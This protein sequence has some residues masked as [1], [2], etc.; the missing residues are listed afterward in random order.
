MAYIT[1]TNASNS[2]LD[3]MGAVLEAGGK[4]LEHVP[5]ANGL[6]ITR[7]AHGTKGLESIATLSHFDF[8]DL[9]T[10]NHQPLSQLAADS[11]F[12]ARAETL[13]KRL[14]LKPLPETEAFAAFREDTVETGVT[15]GANAYARQ[16]A[17]TAA[18]TPRPKDSWNDDIAIVGGVEG[19]NEI[20]GR[21]KDGVRKEDGTLLT[22][23]AARY[24][25]VPRLSLKHLEQVVD[26]IAAHKDKGDDVYVLDYG[27]GHGRFLIPVFDMLGERGL[28]PKILAYDP[29]PNALEALKDNIESRNEIS[30]L[31]GFD[32]RIISYAE[33]SH[34]DVIILN[35]PKYLKQFAGK[36]D[37]AMSM[38]G[39]IHHADSETQLH[40]SLNDI[41][42]TLSGYGLFVGTG[43][44]A[45]LRY[46]EKMLAKIDMRHAGNLFADVSG[47]VPA[48]RGDSEFI[49]T[50]NPDYASKIKKEQAQEKDVAKIAAAYGMDL[51]ELAVQVAE[52]SAQ[53]RSLGHPIYSEGG[54]LTPA[55][56]VAAEQA[57]TMFARHRGKDIVV[58]WTYRLETQES[59]AHLLSGHGIAAETWKPD[60]FNHNDAAAAD[61]ATVQ[62][63]LRLAASP[64]LSGKAQPDTSFDYW[65][66]A[67]NKAGFLEQKVRSD[68]SACMPHLTE[69][70]NY[71]DMLTQHLP[72]FLDKQGFN[73]PFIEKLRDTF[74]NKATS[75]PAWVDN[76]T[77]RHIA[78]S[79]ADI[80]GFEERIALNGSQSI[81]H[82]GRALKGE[83]AYDTYAGIC[84]PQKRAEALQ[85]GEIFLASA[86]RFVAAD[87]AG[88]DHIKAAAS[89][90]AQRL[91]DELIE[92]Y[93][94]YKKRVLQYLCLETPPAPAAARHDAG[95]RENRF[96]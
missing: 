68:I 41:K 55:W 46:R 39:A 11:A 57:D 21:G 64:D 83:G 58:K 66:V 61:P 31:K 5:I 72:A 88:P 75:F 48:L 95:M 6:N 86:A 3:K 10:D 69:Q 82:M 26:R 85:K 27:C 23:Y 50:L 60:C 13:A 8:I 38:A 20:F 1:V 65:F 67:H 91:I 35:D 92:E 47:A 30:R 12:I 78:S 70:P 24:N 42:Q 16:S 32:T 37:L 34:A 17:L 96:S 84:P 90:Q 9:R 89:H 40:N 45:N 87:H 71:G 29:A 33:N 56:H 14:G 22:S 62:Q 52:L 43:P 93:G 7:Y 4:P 80:A 18:H 94:I 36:A 73:K 76:E 25:I 79:V 19:Y 51:E 53:R 28:K 49:N 59:L 2:Y 15:G 77:A 74:N 54:A 81:A 44:T 63:E